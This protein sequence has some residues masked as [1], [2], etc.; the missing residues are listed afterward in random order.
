VHR[1]DPEDIDEVVIE[2]V[3]IESVVIGAPVSP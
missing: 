1:P 3:V 2:Y